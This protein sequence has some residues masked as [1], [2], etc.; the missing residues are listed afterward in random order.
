MI[1]SAEAPTAFPAC[2]P[3]RRSLL[4]GVGVS[5]ALAGVAQVA[6]PTLAAA[7]T[8]DP[9]L[10]LL[11]RA[12]YGPTQSSVAAIKKQ[13]T[14]AWLDAQLAPA[15]ISDSAMDDLLKRWPDLDLRTWECREK[16]G[17]YGENGGSGLAYQ[18]LESFVARAL[19]SERQLFEV[20][21]GFWTNHLVVCVPNSE[22]WDSTHL[23]QRDVIRK[24]AFGRYLDML[25]AAARHP[26]MLKTLDNA[27]SGKLAPN[28]NYGRELLELHTVGIGNYTETDVKNSALALS[29]LSIDNENGLYEYKPQRRYVGPLKVMGWSNTNNSPDNGANVA[30]SYLSY[31]ARH[32]KTAA[33]IATKLCV[34]FVSDTPPAALVSRLAQVYLDNDTSVAPVLKALFTSSEFADAVGQKTK[35]PFEDTIATV[36]VLEAKPESKGTTELRNLVYKLRAMGHAPMGWPAP[37]GYPDVAAAWSGASTILAK[38]NF[39]LAMVGNWTLQGMPRLAAVTFV[40]QTLPTT[41]GALVD[42][43]A[44]RLLLPGLSA[45][46]RAALCKFV[47]KAP[48]DALKSTDS[49]LSYRLPYVLGLL[50]DSYNFAAR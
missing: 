24:Y 50:L 29:G 14:S 42:A 30:L 12:T 36:R 11:R 33:R 6:R 15:S 4:A 13:G 48:T 45:S 18:V 31:L 28:E 25:T 2:R 35:T 22:I 20:T 47:D 46:Q 17:Q 23:F 44:D 39:H 34:R 10:H 9:S 16:Y 27:D 26:A 40:P 1:A 3:S 19:W 5:A 21:V 7:V 32:P 37:N 43:F 49:I 38:W 8:A 41:Y